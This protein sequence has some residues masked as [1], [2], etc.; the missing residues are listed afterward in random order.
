MAIGRSHGAQSRKHL[1]WLVLIFTAA[2]PLRLRMAM[3][4]MSG[5]GYS[6]IPAI[7]LVRRPAGVHSVNAREYG[8]AA[9]EAKG[10]G[11]SSR[12]RSKREQGQRADIGSR[13]V[14]QPGSR[15]L[16]SGDR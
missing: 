11:M 1:P 13:H 2:V 5:Q 7:P 14:T 9:M 3:P 10:S 15:A 12:A 4:A 16:G 8:N 6:R